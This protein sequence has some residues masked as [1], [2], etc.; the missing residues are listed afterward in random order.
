MAT[1]YFVPK[2]NAVSVVELN[3]APG[4]LIAAKFLAEGI[5]RLVPVHHGGA[6]RTY[7]TSFTGGLMDGG[8]PAARVHIRSPF[9][10][11]LEYGTR[12]SAPYRPIQKAATALGLR[13]LPS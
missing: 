7:E 2:P 11:F 1:A 8:H 13:Y 9:W 10:H 4:L 12:F 6:K 3:A 5:P